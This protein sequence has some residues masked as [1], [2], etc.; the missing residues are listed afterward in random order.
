M[1]LQDIL[2]RA[3]QGEEAARRR[4]PNLGLSQTPEEVVP[5]IP[6]PVNFAPPAE[7]QQDLGPMVMA[8]AAQQAG[9]GGGMQGGMQGGGQGSDASFPGATGSGGT[10]ALARRI[11]GWIEGV[12]GT[13]FQVSGLEGFQGT[14]QISTGHITDSQHY[15]GNAGDVS[16]NG[17]SRFGDEMAA[18]DWLYRRLQQR[19]GDQLTELIWR[20]PDHWDHLHYGTRPGG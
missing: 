10:T 16:Y 2:D 7:P 4:T 17:G 11:A 12:P 20:Q 13:D 3:F 14:G 8:L 19:W 18:N 1:A 5:P 6:G 9:G 15:T